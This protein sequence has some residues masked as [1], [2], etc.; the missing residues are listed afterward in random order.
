MLPLDE[1][2]GRL[3]CQPV[4]KVSGRDELWYKSPFREEEEASL[5]ISR[6]HHP[7]LGLIWVW[8]DFGDEGG[9]VIDF[10]QRY[11]RLSDITSVLRKLAEMGYERRRAP[12]PAPLLEMIQSTQA[13]HQDE[14]GP[15]THVRFEKL[16]NR[17]LLGYL[18]GRGKITYATAKPYV[19]EIKYHLRGNENG[20]EFFA[21]AF[22]ND[23]GGYELRNGAGAREGK[24]GFKGVYGRKDIS[25]LHW[26]KLAASQAV[27]VFEGFFDYLSALTYYGKQAADTPVIVLNTVELKQKA[28]T[29]IQQMG[30]SKVH[31]YLDNDRKGREATAFFQE[32]LADCE[33]IDHACLY[34]GYDDLNDFLVA[35]C[36]KTQ[37]GSAA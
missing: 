31:L 19:Q 16:H 36:K 28:A 7:R 11:Y 24:L 15:F 33:V 10:I 30:A 1:I 23:S 35:E 18:Y 27:A 26:E 29:A 4:K 5:H 12:Q 17:A 13:D 25:T 6:V 8:K 20:Q 9:T 21:L 34:A 2:L 3:G 22:P 32:Q 14:S 37:M